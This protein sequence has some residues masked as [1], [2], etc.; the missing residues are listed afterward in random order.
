MPID[1]T[2]ADPRNYELAKNGLLVLRPV[3][4]NLGYEWY[5]GHGTLLGAVREHDLI[6]HDND[7]DCP[8]NENAD[9]QKVADAL[10]AADFY[11]LKLEYFGISAVVPG[12]KKSKEDPWDLHVDIW[13]QYRYPNNQVFEVYEK[14]PWVDT[15][16]GGHPMY[17]KFIIPAPTKIIRTTFLGEEFPIPE[18]Y[19]D[20]L[21][22][23][24]GD[25]HKVVKDYKTTDSTNFGLW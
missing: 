15:S 21:T 22:V 7:I 20:I 8:I 13:K 2:F 14:G 19:D 25:W 1:I 11:I 16:D 12:A 6:F 4:D 23:E 17:N 24:Y 3:L 5:L 9:L 10:T 18:N